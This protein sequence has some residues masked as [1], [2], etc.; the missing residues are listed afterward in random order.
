MRLDVLYTFK[1][2][3]AQVKFVMHYEAIIYAERLQF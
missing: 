2:V 3:K 1:M